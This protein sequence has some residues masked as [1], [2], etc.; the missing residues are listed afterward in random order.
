MH[1]PLSSSPTL[2]FSMLAK[3]P[4]ATL[5]ILSLLAPGSDAQLSRPVF[6]SSWTDTASR[7]S[8]NPPHPPLMFVTAHLDSDDHL[9]IATCNLRSGTIIGSPAQVSIWRGSGDG[10]FE[11]EVGASNGASPVWIAAIDMTGNGIDDLLEANPE[12]GSGLPGEVR[13]HRF[14]P[15]GTILSPLLVTMGT[16]PGAVAAADFDLDGYMDLVSAQWGSQDVAIRR[17]QFTIFPTT[18][19]F[20]PANTFG[21]VLDAVGITTGDMNE[22]GFP[23]VVVSDGDGNKV[24]LFPGNGDGTL[25]PQVEILSVGSPS[26]ATIVDVNLD[27]HLD[28][29]ASSFSVIQIRVALG[30]GDGTFTAAPPVPIPTGAAF[31]DAADLDGDGIPDL[32]VA[33]GVGTLARL[34]RCGHIELLLEVHVS[35]SRATSRFR[36]H[37]NP[38]LQPGSAAGCDPLS[39]SPARRG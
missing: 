10:R 5:C 36:G 13:I 38:D 29:V 2:R 32:T 16:K 20:A 22:D 14:S 35:I 4:L 26:V 33:T 11:A 39:G 6:A 27:G 31:V 19:S 24:Y 34:P 21:T 23:D 1:A 7:N 17:G 8:V 3:A 18:L 25:A 37:S 30:A 9:D 15:S 12:L 28:V